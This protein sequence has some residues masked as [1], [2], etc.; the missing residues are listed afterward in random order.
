MLFLNNS[1][2]DVLLYTRVE[3]DGK[4]VKPVKVVFKPGR[5]REKPYHLELVLQLPPRL[6]TIPKVRNYTIQSC[7]YSYHQG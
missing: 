3:V 6:G 7:S 5:D 4:L 2:V 1:L